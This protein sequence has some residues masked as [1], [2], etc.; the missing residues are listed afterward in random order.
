[1]TQESRVFI[2][3]FVHILFSMLFLDYSQIE[4][5]EEII[6]GLYSLV[7]QKYGKTSLK[8]VFIKDFFGKMNELTKDEIVEIRKEMTDVYMK[9]ELIF[10]SSVYLSL[11]KFCAKMANPLKYFFDLLND[12]VE[13]HKMVSALENKI[14]KFVECSETLK[15]KKEYITMTLNKSH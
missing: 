14:G 6:K 2:L 12:Y 7:Y 4:K 1:M 11:S 13:K 9:N 3:P 15:K 5:E 10:S 8:E